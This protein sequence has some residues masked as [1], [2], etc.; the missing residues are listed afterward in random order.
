VYSALGLTGVLTEAQ[1]ASLDA[2]ATQYPDDPL[3]KSG[4]VSI[5]LD[6]SLEAQ[7]AAMLAPYADGSDGAAPAIAPDDLNRMVRLLDARG[8]Q[9]LTSASGDRAVRMALNAYEHAV[10]SNPVPERGRRHRIERVTLI[11][12]A[13]APRFSALG[14]VA[15]MQPASFD[16][17]PDRL[18]LL[19]G[20][21]GPARAAMTMA[22]GTIARTSGTLAF[23][24]D[25]PYAPLN[26]LRAL[27]AA[28]TRTRAEAGADD[29]VAWTPAERLKLQA[30]IDA[31]TSAAAWA[32]F[33][34]QRK[35]TL[36]NGMLADLVVLSGDVFDVPPARLLSTRV[37]L[38]VFDGKIVYRR[39][40][41]STN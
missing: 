32:S 31:Y 25:W 29:A 17:G 35:G 12:P 14:V 34:E 16:P 8:W 1:V 39:G 9:V 2:I 18:D 41:E 33:D 4:A 23:G 40:G 5:D 26:P 13:D 21:V 22:Y 10:R 3:F 15:S 24:S 37:A 20:T 36:A 6:G 27:Y 30:S 19:L 7:A 38:T 11:D 28:V